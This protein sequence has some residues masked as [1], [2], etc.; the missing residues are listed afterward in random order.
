MISSFE[1]LVLT[2]ITMLLLED[3]VSGLCRICNVR[4]WSRIAMAG[5]VTAPMCISQ[6]RLP[7]NRDVELWRGLGKLPQRKPTRPCPRVTAMEALQP[8]VMLAMSN[9]AGK[10]GSHE[11]HGQ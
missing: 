4:E 6:L 10:M 3:Q 11:N 2:V 9:Y 1:L 7:P 5:N 8:T